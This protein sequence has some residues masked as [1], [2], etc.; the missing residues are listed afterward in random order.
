MIT[1]IVKMM[2]VDHLI[3]KNTRLH[4]MQSTVLNTLIAIR[5]IRLSFDKN[6]IEN[7]V[8]CLYCLQWL[9]KS[10]CEYQILFRNCDHS[11]CDNVCGVS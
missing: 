3:F 1:I 8:A 7:S 6:V 5:I 11:C 10:V 4:T 2:S 9:W